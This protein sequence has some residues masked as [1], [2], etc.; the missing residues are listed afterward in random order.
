[1]EDSFL[2]HSRKRNIEMKVAVVL[3]TSWNIYNFR[4]SLLKALA[5]QGHEVHTIAPLDD[6]TPYLT[7]AGF[8]HHNVRMDSRG[9]NPIKDM[10]LVLEFG[11]I[12]KRIK[13][14]V[15]LHFTIKPNIYGTLAARLLNIPVINN[16]CGLGTVFLKKGIVSWVAKSLYKLA[17]RFPKKVFFQNEDDQQLFVAEKLVKG[18]LTGLLP[19]SG[20]NVSE[21][22]PVPFKTNKEFTFLLVARL[23]YDKGI[24]EYIEAIRILRK[25]GVKARFQLLG[26]TDPEHK[27]GI[28]LKVLDEWIKEGLVDY[29]GKTKNV[30]GFVNEADCIVL[31]SYREGSPRSLMEAA[32]LQKPIITTDVAGCRH[33]VEHQYNGLLCKLQNPEDLAGKMEEM[34]RLPEADRLRMGTNGRKKMEKEFSDKIIIKKYLEA[35]DS[36]LG[37]QMKPLEPMEKVA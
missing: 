16:V 31:P 22:V 34:M 21:F 10:A 24:A 28:S 3:N 14:D 20:I 8:T 5:E 11:S 13:P 4:M 12:Y 2:L 35:I 25:Y 27:R 17:F 26:G 15:V 36:I 1:M 7:A 9:A 33:V 37:K 19:G 29:L 32:C 30:Q 23:I 18:E 6:F